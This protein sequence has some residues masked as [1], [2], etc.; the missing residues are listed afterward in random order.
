MIIQLDLSLSSYFEHVLRL[1]V[2]VFIDP[3]QKSMLMFGQ[4]S[5]RV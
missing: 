2:H 5:V 1:A 3:A 4:S